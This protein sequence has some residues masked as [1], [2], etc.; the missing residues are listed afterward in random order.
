VKVTVTFELF[1]PAAVGAGDA[2]ALIVGGVLS[3]LTVTDVEAVFPA[4]SVA[5]PDI[6]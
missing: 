2:E 5:V 4:M 1:H 6:T 3:R